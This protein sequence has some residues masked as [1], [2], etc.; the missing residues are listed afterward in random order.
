MRECV[1]ALRRRAGE[2]EA[3]P[4]FLFILWLARRERRWCPSWRKA[5]LKG[6]RLRRRVLQY[7]STVTMRTLNLLLLYPVPSSYTLVEF[8]IFNTC[9]RLNIFQIPSQ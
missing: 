5:E 9:L 2:G 7:V 6:A 8:H 1:H 4:G 3:L